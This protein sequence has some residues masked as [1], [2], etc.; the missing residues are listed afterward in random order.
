MDNTT[1]KDN[2][3]KCGFYCESCRDY[4][5]GK[6]KGCLEEHKEGDCY[7]RDCVLESEVEFC[8]L[9]NKFPC[10]YIIENE[11]C[12]VLDKKW[13]IWKRSKKD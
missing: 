9:C 5:N 6:C 7:T 8:G 10:D 12:T 1:L 2:I 4:V 11:K 13:L 3:G